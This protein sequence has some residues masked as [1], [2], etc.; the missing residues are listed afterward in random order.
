VLIPTDELG[1]KN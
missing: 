1:K